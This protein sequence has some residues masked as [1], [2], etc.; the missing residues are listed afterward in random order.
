MS[1][2]PLPTAAEYQSEPVRYPT[3]TVIDVNSEASAIELAAET[4]FLGTAPR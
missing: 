3:L 4:V 2:H 1:K